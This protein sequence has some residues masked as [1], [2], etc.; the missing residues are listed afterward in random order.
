MLSWSHQG[1]IDSEAAFARLAGAAPIPASSGQTIR[2]RLDRSGDRKLN[3]A[4]HMILVTRKRTHPATIAYIERR[5]AEGKTRREANRCLKRYLARSLYRLL[6]H[7][8]PIDDLTDIEASLAQA[9]AFALVAFDAAT[10]AGERAER[11]ADK[12]VWFI[13]GAGR[14]MGVDIAQAALTAG[15]AV[16]AT[17]R[18][19]DAV[20]ERGGRDRRPARRRTR[21]HERGVG[22]S[23][24]AGC[25]SAFR[26]H[27]CA[28]QQRGQLLCRFLRGAVT[29]AVRGAVDDEPLGPLNVTRAVLPVMRKQRAGHIVTISST[30]GI[31]GQEFC[32]AYAASKFGLEGW[33]ESLRFEIEPFGIHIII[34]ELFF[35]TDRSRRNPLLTLTPPSK[36]R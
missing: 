16:V 4:L 20:A 28:G 22:R 12:R 3:R 26:P 18:K 36:I 34:V 11:M 29:G 31:V 17:G 5:L 33:M 14:G 2:Y 7:G 10:T 13:T 24:G 19:T 23:G 32:S 25:F 21:H 9:T 8:P 27:R 6:E 15:H 30:A 1:R 35:R